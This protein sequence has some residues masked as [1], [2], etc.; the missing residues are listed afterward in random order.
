MNFHDPRLP[1]AEAAPV[2]TC[3]CVVIGPGRFTKLDGTPAPDV[4]GHWEVALCPPC[5]EEARRRA[6]ERERLVAAANTGRS[7]S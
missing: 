6:E 7:A 4:P 2:F 5:I 3:G 1:A